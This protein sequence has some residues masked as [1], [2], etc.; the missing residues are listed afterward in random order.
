MDELELEPVRVREE[1][2]VVVGCV[3][4]I[5]G[6][7]VE[8]G[9]AD[10]LQQ[11]EEPVHVF[12]ARRMERQVME[13]GGV[14]IVL[15]PYT[16]GTPDLQANTNPAPFGGKRFRAGPTGAAPRGVAVQGLELFS[17]LPEARDPRRTLHPPLETQQKR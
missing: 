17:V 6:R 4:R 2:G 11:F 1:N 14:A 13:P 15:L 3:L 12:P 8:E 10:L 16:W 7:G 9:R 5:L